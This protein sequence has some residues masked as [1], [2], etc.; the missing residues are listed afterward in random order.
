MR[1]IAAAGSLP[2]SLVCAGCAWVAPDD[3]PYPFRC[4]N[5]ATPGL[6]DVDHVVTRVLDPGR[7]EWPAAD[8]PNPFLAYRILFHATHVGRAHGMSD[9]DLG[10]VIRRLDRAVEAVDGRGFRETP[11]A[12]SRVLSA[13]LRFGPSGEVWVKDETGNVSGSHKARHLFGL[14]LHLEV[15]ERLGLSSKRDRPPLAIASCGNAALAAAVVARAAQRAL[16]VFVPTDAD[17]VVVA[18]LKELDANVV[19][20]PRD[21]NV[22][23]DPTVHR[24]RR[25][26]AEGALPFTCQGNENGLAIE[27]GLTLGYEM[28]TALSRLP[29]ALDRVIVQVGGGA[30]V[31][32]V[33]Q[34]LR[35][36]AELGQAP[37]PAVHTV[38]TRGAH[39]L[40]RAFDL[41]TARVRSGEPFED[42]LRY[43][44]AH[45]SAFMWPWEE[46]PRSVAHGILDDETYDWVAAVR[47]M[48]ES[49]GGATVV[50]EA[51]LDEA[52]ALGVAA[53]GIPA[54]HTG[55]SGLA[56]LMALRRDAVVGDDERVA[57]L[58]TGV[59][60]EPHGTE[61]RE[62]G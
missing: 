37:V 62:D 26:L 50:D 10:G 29:A 36:A 20:C 5:I 46:A 22:P 57:V 52:N 34:G 60:R 14:L 41:V 4:P 7:L 11:F 16:D 15:M 42:A 55:T 39:P 28:A 23:G 18:R 35:E 49:G 27:G 53:T 56:G 59:R 43:A 3:D 48:G 30:L 38:Q 6:A 17:P 31:S 32:A 19:T 45:R 58:F 44:A 8:D 9:A 2:S 51:T 33:A 54:D 40:Q 61:P 47:A 24:L 1:S 12:P 21:P 13:R 25:A